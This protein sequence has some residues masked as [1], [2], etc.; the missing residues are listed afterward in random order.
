MKIYRLEDL[1]SGGRKVI[2]SQDVKFMEDK[3]PS[4][5]T[6]VDVRGMIAT[7]KEIDRLID[8]VISLDI[9]KLTISS[10]GASSTPDM[11]KS[12]TLSSQVP[13]LPSILTPSITNEGKLI[14]LTSTSLILMDQNLMSNKVVPK[15]VV[16]DIVLATTVP[17]WTST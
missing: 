11:S 15:N 9:G 1:E 8:D 2:A 10:L 14:Y 12:I 13:S 4:N 6:V 17:C 7:A 5:F 16:K 3:S